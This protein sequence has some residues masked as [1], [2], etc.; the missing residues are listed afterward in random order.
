MTTD[1]HEARSSLP[2]T[3]GLRPW[4]LWL[5]A[6]IIAAVAVGVAATRGDSSRS[7]VSSPGTEQLASIQQACVQWREGPAG[8][9][10][11]SSAWCEAMVRWM[12][13]EMRSGE[14]MGSMMW[15]DPQQMLA[16]CQRWMSSS[17]WADR[18]TPRTPASCGQMVDW[19]T[20]HIGDWD[21][22]DGG[23]MMNGPGG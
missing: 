17:Q 13:D 8:S 14:M 15:S 21:R 3:G 16:T 10:A 5:L 9:A 6:L 11:P 2:D 7:S 20:R 4:W 19:M 22:W 23:W 18:S 1:V 12:S